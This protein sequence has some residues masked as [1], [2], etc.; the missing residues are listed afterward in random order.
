MPIALENENV[1]TL[2]QIQTLTGV[3][4][5]KILVSFKLKPKV[6]ETMEERRRG[7]LSSVTQTNQD[8]Q[9]L[10]VSTLG[11]CFFY[12]ALTIDD[13]AIEFK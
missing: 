4:T 7:I 12:P 3:E 5:Q 6:V 11:K 10:S 2:Q 1:L 9:T 13:D 8:Q